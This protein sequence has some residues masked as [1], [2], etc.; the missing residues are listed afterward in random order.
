MPLI[1]LF[2]KYFDKNVMF[3]VVKRFAK[4]QNGLNHDEIFLLHSGRY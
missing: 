2:K 4:I 3:F 1:L